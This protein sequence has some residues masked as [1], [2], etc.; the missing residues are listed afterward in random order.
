MGRTSVDSLKS[1]GTT[2]SRYAPANMFAGANRPTMSRRRDQLL[3]P[4]PAG[5]SEARTAGRGHAPPDFCPQRKKFP[6]QEELAL[7][8]TSWRP[9]Q[10]V[11]ELRFRRAPGFR[12]SGAIC[13]DDATDISLAADLCAMNRTCSSSLR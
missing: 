13:Y 5:S 11:I 3:G 6:T 10:V 9:H 1:R 7:G 12:L 8:V 2:A 4:H